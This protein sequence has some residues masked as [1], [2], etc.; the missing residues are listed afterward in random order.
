MP[1][2]A[3]AET[4][5]YLEEPTGKTS[6]QTGSW[7][8]SILSSEIGGPGSL[9]GKDFGYYVYFELEDS[10]SYYENTDTQQT[11]TQASFNMDLN[12]SS[13]IEFGGMYHDYAGNQ[14]AGWN[15]L[16]QDLVDN[17]TYITGSP[18]A[19]DRD[20][21]GYISHLEYGL[22]YDTLGFDY[23]TDGPG[24]G[25]NSNFG[26]SLDGMDAFAF[27]TSVA[28]AGITDEDIP[29]AYALQNPGTT[30]L[31]GSQVLVSPEDTLENEVT[32]LYFD[33]IYEPSESFSITNKL[34][35][36]SYENL[37]ENAYG[38]SQFHDSYVVEEQLIFAYSVESDALTAA[39]QLSPS[40]RY[41]DFAHGDDYSNEFF[42]RRDL[43]GPS[44]ALDRRLLA[45]QIDDDYT[46]YYEGHY[47]DIG[48]AFLADLDFSF[49]LNVLLG[50]RQDYID[51]ESN[52]PVDKLLCPVIDENGNFLSLSADQ[53]SIGCEGTTESVSDDTEG[54]SWTASV[55]YE[56]PFGLTPYATF[57][58]QYTLI[59]GQG[60]E[61]STG[62]IESDSYFD[63]SELT[64]FGIR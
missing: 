9:F 45:T 41:T 36:E 31:D 60:A 24:G 40:Y 57:S 10:G 51:I 39:F 8:K 5:Q 20:G 6:Y 26:A 33:Y 13:R 55:S 43:T 58:E 52:T 62:S 27:W 18:L 22:A 59:A 44:T 2:S 25:P 64:E 1:K 3:R 42:D 47:S 16:T 14:V 29:E 46:E 28:P 11:V 61:V 49:G 17:G 15:R 19:L 35:F 56:L 63:T 12:D 7:D 32:T 34:F 53:F 4:G 54:T 50:V 37:N 21:D 48:L 30:T 38:F 23:D